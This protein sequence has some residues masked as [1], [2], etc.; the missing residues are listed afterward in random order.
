VGLGAELAAHIQEVAFNDLDAPI[1]R[2]SGLDIAMPYAKNLE[3]ATLPYA[4]D[5]VTAVKA[6]AAKQY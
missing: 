4:E 5:V 2:V 6:M 3:R 1:A